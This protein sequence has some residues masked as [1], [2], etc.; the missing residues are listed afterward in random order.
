MTGIQAAP[1]KKTMDRTIFH[2]QLVSG[3]SKRVSHGIALAREAINTANK[4]R[5]ECGKLDTDLV[6]AFCNM[7]SLWC[8]RVLIRKGLDPQVVDW[9]LNL[10]TDNLS[11]VVLNN[12]QGRCIANNR[13]SV[14]Q[15]DKFAMELFSFGMD[16][17]IDYLHKRLK[18]ILIHSSP[19]LGPL[20]QH[21][22]PF[23]YPVP[24]PAPD[25]PLNPPVHPPPHPPPVPL[26]DDDTPGLT[27]VRLTSWAP[28]LS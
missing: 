25:P 7:V 18:G 15:G 14:R 28:P 23:Q 4:S 19:R 6:A 27:R 5:E 13:M 20:P 24:T 3:E 16:P 9:Y 17:I 2:L 12:I 8:F 21:P 11:I 10:Y 1:I 22:P 26:S